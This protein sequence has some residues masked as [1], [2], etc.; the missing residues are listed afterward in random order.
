MKCLV[1][2]DE[3]KRMAQLVSKILDMKEKSVSLRGVCCLRVE[4]GCLYVECVNCLSSIC[5]LSVHVPCVVEDEG[6][7]CVSIKAL[8]A[9]IKSTNDEHVAIECEDGRL[10]LTSERAHTTMDIH[11]EFY[12]FIQECL[13][14]SSVI[15]EGFCY[16]VNA[17]QLGIAM[18]YTA[19]ALSKDWDRVIFTGVLME[20]DRDTLRF[21]GSDGHRAH[22]AHVTMCDLPQHPQVTLPR[23]A[24]DAISGLKGC[25]DVE[26]L[27]LSKGVCA[28]FTTES[29]RIMAKGIEGTW[30]DI[31]KVLRLCNSDWDIRLDGRLFCKAT[32]AFKGNLNAMSEVRFCTRDGKVSVSNWG[33]ESAMT[34]QLSAESNRESA[35]MDAYSYNL[36][37]LWDM[38]DVQG[39]STIGCYADTQV[40]SESP[41]LIRSEYHSVEF[42]GMLMPIA[43]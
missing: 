24:V 12:I 15:R 14:E 43:T 35:Y 29:V 23:A 41:C 39:V 1:N 4:D 16:R 13:H 25:V 31:M 3:F 22:V 11:D 33:A 8:M 34:I 21:V 36:K 26:V 7:A 40:G 2:F 17:D 27:K 9:F 30:P 32:K 38:L 6:H 20:T 28:I 37:Y 5:S 42:L 10:T 18:G 19:R